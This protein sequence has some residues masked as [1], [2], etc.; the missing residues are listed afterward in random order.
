MH[1]YMFRPLEGHDQ[2]DFPVKTT[3]K[4]VE[5]ILVYVIILVCLNYTS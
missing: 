5:R 4:F 2:D 1:I 3:V